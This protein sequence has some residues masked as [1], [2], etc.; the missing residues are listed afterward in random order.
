MAKE[1]EE[2]SELKPKE[3]VKAPEQM[4]V[5]VKESEDLQ[6]KGYKVV[7]MVKENKVRLH[8]LVKG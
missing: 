1:K 3:E 7:G 2:V 4:K 8:I 6:K 5:S